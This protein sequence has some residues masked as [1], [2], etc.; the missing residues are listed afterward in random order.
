M[1]YHVFYFWFIVAA[2]KRSLYDQFG[3]DGLK[4]GCGGGG[5]MGES[6]V[7]PTVSY[8]VIVPCLLMCV[9]VCTHAH[10]STCFYSIS[11]LLLFL[12]ASAYI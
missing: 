9:C 2:N 1:A 10:G 3:K 12:L 6:Q 5:G 11:W 7:T 8:S 4:Q